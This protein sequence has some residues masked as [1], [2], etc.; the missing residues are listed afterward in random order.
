MLNCEAMLK[1]IK[2]QVE[3]S[4]DERGLPMGSKIFLAIMILVFFL[5]SYGI[6]VFVS[7]GMKDML[8]EDTGAREGSESR[9]SPN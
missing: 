4:A 3:G 6:R 7:L 9:K 2:E 5:I 1:G 8:Q